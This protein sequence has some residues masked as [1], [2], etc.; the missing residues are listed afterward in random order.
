MAKLTES[1]DP[2]VLVEQIKTGN[3]E[4]PEVKDE[5]VTGDRP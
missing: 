5:T 2:K 4:R 1:M 3:C